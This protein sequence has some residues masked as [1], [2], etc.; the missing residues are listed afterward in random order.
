M[1]YELARS[2]VRMPRS[3]KR[4]DGCKRNEEVGVT[5]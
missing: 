1:V 4:D 5:R 3:S 2:S